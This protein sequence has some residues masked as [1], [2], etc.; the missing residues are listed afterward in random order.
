MLK[1]AIICAFIAVTTINSR[2][3]E[4]ATLNHIGIVVTDAKK[5]MEF[6]EQWFHLDSIKCPFPGNIRWLSLGG[7][8]QLHLIGGE[9][10]EVLP[11]KENHIAFSVASVADYAKQ[12]DKAAI[13]YSDGSGHFGKFATRPDGVHQIYF[14]DPDGYRLEVNDAR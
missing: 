8:M 10:S 1:R 3:Q 12:L 14:L 2:A 13:P 6:Y 9:K 7:S 11:S 5:S 4:K